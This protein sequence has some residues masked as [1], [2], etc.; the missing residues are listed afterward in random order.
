MDSANAKS[1]LVKVIQE[2]Q[3]KSGLDC[4]T[5]TGSTK[6]LDDVEEF[7]SKIAIL[8]TSKLAKR[9]KLEIPEKD[10]VFFDVKSKVKFT[11]DQTVEKLCG[12]KAAKSGKEA[13][14]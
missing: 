7:C 5:L 11:L 1:E 12:Y 8:A 10:N 14:A 6:P 2:I 4:P 13:A 9:L 3:S